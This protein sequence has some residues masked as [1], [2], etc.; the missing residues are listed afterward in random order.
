MSTIAALMAKE[1]VTAEPHESVTAVAARMARNGVGAVVIVD[2]G[3]LAGLVTERDVLS[4]VVGSHSDPDTTG[5]GSVSTVEIESVDIGCSL[6]DALA[7]FRS[8]RFRHLPVLQDGK[9]VGILST[10]DLHGY[11]IDEFERFIDDL[12]YRKE[13]ADG[14]DP[15]DHFGGQYGR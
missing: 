1:L 13:L 14:I 8:K 3:K 2:K 7:R 11:L 9:P 10:T 6:K 5:I 12:K 4:R 15:Y